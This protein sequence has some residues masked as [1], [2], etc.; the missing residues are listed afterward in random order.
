VRG[1]DEHFRHAQKAGAVILEEPTDTKY[2]NRRYGATDPEGHEW[3]FA[4]ITR[5]PKSKRKFEPVGEMTFSDEVQDVLHRAIVGARELGHAVM[6]PEH[7]ALELIRE[8]ETAAYLERCGTN[9]VAV[10]S[11]LRAYLGRVETVDAD[12]LE[13]KPSPAFQRVL[14]RAVEHT[15]ADDREY[16]VLRDLFLALID[17]RD[18]IASLA[19]REATG[20]VETFEELRTYRSGEERGAV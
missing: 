18:G 13:T 2:G 12:E 17:E 9:L 19:I 16:L 4:Q 15:E 14:R 3:Y 5:R 6:T 8:D 1:V 20:E 7:L 11:R 10:E